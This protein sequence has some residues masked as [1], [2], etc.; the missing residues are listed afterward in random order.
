MPSRTTILCLCAVAL[1]GCTRPKERTPV[2]RPPVTV[3]P[4]FCDVDGLYRVRFASNGNYGW[5]LR[6]R[7]TQGRAEILQERPILGL[8]PGPIALT[9][10]RNCA[11]TM[12]KDTEQAGH[13]TL[14]LSADPKGVLTG[15]LHRTKVYVP[16]EAS[17]PVLGR[18][19]R[20]PPD[21]PACLHPGAFKLHLGRKRSWKLDGTPGVRNTRAACQS[22]GRFSEVF[23]S[24]EP[25]GDDL[26]VDEASSMEP[27]ESEG[28]RGEVDRTG[29]CAITL[30]FD[31]T[32]FSLAKA[33][34][35]FD[36]DK[37]TGIA[38]RAKVQMFEDG[39]DGE[40]L[41]TCEAKDIAVLGERVA[42][43]YT[44]GMDPH[45][46]RLRE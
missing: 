6:F 20:Q 9:V 25:L 22:L 10:D 30:S 26:M 44:T 42:D 3:P 37:I 39:E 16:K 14:K 40:N 18:R 11:L 29:P 34:L 8:M 2:A 45:E 13:L 23:I 36:G 27:Y 12:E 24:V 43:L 41:W 1:Q 35:T 33:R 7:I 32:D 21:L 4:K 28:R 19:E 38:E 5:W 17:S 46:E 15:E 31:W